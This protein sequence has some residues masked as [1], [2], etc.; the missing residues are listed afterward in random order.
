MKILIKISLFPLL[1]AFSGCC[2][3]PLEPLA[4]VVS[5]N[6]M[7]VTDVELYTDAN[8]IPVIKEIT[9]HLNQS[10]N[11]ATLSKESVLTEGLDNPEI[12]TDIEENTIIIRGTPNNCNLFGDPQYCTVHITLKGTGNTPVNSKLN[13]PIDGDQDNIEGGDYSKDFFF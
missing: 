13:T 1:F 12:T 7:Q 5:G 6:P 3:E 8:S 2:S 4:P 10:L 11:P 9:I